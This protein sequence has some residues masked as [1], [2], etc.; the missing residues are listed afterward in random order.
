MVAMIEDIIQQSNAVV[1]AYDHDR[2]AESEW[3]EQGYN[4]PAINFSSQNRIMEGVTLA[5]MG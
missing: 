4:R 2:S 5:F 1:P 3:I